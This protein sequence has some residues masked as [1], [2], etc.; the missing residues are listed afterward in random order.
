[1][2]DLVVDR[3]MIAG[4]V[5]ALYRYADD[6]TYF[7]LRAFV[8][9]S[10]GGSWGNW[11]VV[12]VNGGGLSELIETAAHFAQRCANAAEPVV[13]CPPI[14]AL[15]NAITAAEKDVA[16]GLALSVECDQA[17]SKARELLE[18]LLGPATVLVA[19]GGEWRPA[20][21]QQVE[22][23]LHLHWRLQEPT[24]AHADHL[25]L[26]EAR[27][28]AQRLV[29][30]DGSAVP[31]VHPLRWPGSWHRKGEPRLARIVALN[32]SAEIDLGGALELLREAID[33]RGGD[34]SAADYT[35]R[36][37]SDLEADFFAIASALA[38][39][40]NDDVGWDEWNKVGMATWAASGGSEAGF[41]A[42][43]NWSRKSA[44]YNPTVTRER[45]D[46]I[47]KYPQT[48]SASGPSRISRK[49][50]DRAGASQAR[51]PSPSLRVTRSPSSL[52]D[53]G[54]GKTQPRR[55]RAR[56]PPSSTPDWTMR[57][58]RPA[59]GCSAPYFA[60]K[61]CRC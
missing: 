35:T 20:F 13:F 14:V 39:I 34:A 7:Q 18:R 42:F 32:E 10:D 49:K 15:K 16:N 29:G 56:G 24:R 3:D 27:R 59:A 36:K 23:K 60:A 52:K 33:A 37:A 8:D 45:W 55:R 19:S 57:R 5:D 31:L 11:P 44:K 43:D 53:T 46:H 41:H 25:L 58:S 2:S 48:G 38:V 61:W 50:P 17:P 54:L 1:M 21:S 22:P 4:F 28:L 51:I 9:R 6:G 47:S 30:A 26:K 12:K 40:P